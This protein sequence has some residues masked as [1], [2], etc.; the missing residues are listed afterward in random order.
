MQKPDNP[1]SEVPFATPLCKGYR[2]FIITYPPFRR[3]TPELI[4]TILPFV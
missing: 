1:K 3:I 4:F 2:V